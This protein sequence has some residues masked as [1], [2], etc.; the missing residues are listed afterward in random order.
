MFLQFFIGVHCSFLYKFFIHIFFYDLIFSGNNSF[1]H[2]TMEMHGYRVFN[3]CTLE[4]QK[5]LKCTYDQ[6]AHISLNCST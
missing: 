1:I 3:F 5:Q 6:K 2:D 4:L